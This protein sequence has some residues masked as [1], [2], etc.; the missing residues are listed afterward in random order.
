MFKVEHQQGLDATHFW[1]DQWLANNLLLIKKQVTQEDMDATI[2]ITGKVGSGKSHLTGQI[3]AFF[4]SH[5]TE[6]SWVFNPQQ[7]QNAVLNFPRYS[8]I[9]YEEAHN[10][11]GT[12]T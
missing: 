7:F 2:I 6:K 1:M 8:V 4:D 12:R 9:I 5:I 3:G 10:G 11:F